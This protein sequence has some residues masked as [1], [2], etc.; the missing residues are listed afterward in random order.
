MKNLRRC[1]ALL[2]SAPPGL[3]LIGCTTFQY[4]GKNNT[5]QPVIYTAYVD[6]DAK[7]SIPVAAGTTIPAQ[8]VGDFRAGKK[9]EIDVSRPGGGRIAYAFNRL[10]RKPDPYLLSLDSPATIPGETLDLS[11]PDLQAALQDVSNSVGSPTALVG[12]LRDS[13]LGGVYKFTPNASDSLHPVLSPIASPTELDDRVEIDL[14]DPTLLP[15]SYSAILYLDQTSEAKI[16]AELPTIASLSANFS[17]S[18]LSEY[19]LDFKNVGWRITP[20]NWYS[21]RQ[22][23]SGTPEGKRRLAN[24][25]DALSNLKGGERIVYLNQAYVISSVDVTDYQMT[26]LDAKTDIQASTYLTAN[27]AYSRT[28]VQSDKKTGKGIVVRVRYSELQT[29]DADPIG[30]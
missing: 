27:G 21:V 17:G 14:L 5:D 19:R 16:A 29:G 25:K 4:S 6:D 30:P 23:L 10:P 28:G 18:D 22:K 8:T 24:I 20:L 12:V 9:I 7:A 1:I 26:K 13:V 3:I 15:L 11:K 2:M